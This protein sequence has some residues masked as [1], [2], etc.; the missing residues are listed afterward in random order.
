M[1]AQLEEYL[2]R[3]TLRN[4]AEE[5][6]VQAQGKEH[7]AARWGVQLRPWFQHFSGTTGH[8]KWNGFT[9]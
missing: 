1:A 9:Q 5:K 7:K 8:K 2:A 6:K 4:H 3:K